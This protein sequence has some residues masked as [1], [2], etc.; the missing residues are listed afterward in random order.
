MTPEKKREIQHSLEGA[1]REV[2]DLMHELDMSAISIYASCESSDYG[3]AS[4]WGSDDTDVPCA[5]M[6]V[7]PDKED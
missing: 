6:T 1:V 7:W 4:V 2:I 5:S 3:T